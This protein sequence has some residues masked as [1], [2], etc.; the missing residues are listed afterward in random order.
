[1]AP[2]AWLLPVVAIRW[3]R[4]GRPAGRI[5]LG[6][7]GAAAALYFGW[8]GVASVMMPPA[9]YT[10][11]AATAAVV[12]VSPYLVDRFVAK[13]YDTFAQTLVFPTSLVT[14]EYLLNLVS[15]LG[16][17]NA[18]AY[19]QAPVLPLIQ[20]AA[21]TGIW[22]VSFVVAWFGAVVNWVFEKGFDWLKV[23]AGILFFAGALGLILLTGAA[24]V[25]LF[26]G[27]NKVVRVAGIC[28]RP[29]LLTAHPEITTNLLAGERLPA[30]ER[31][32][33]RDAASVIIDDLFARTVRE[34]R[35]GARIIVW[36][37]A[38]AMT[39]A[40]DERALIS[41]GQ[42]TARAERIYLAMGIGVLHDRDVKPFENKIV[43][44][45][46]AGRVIWNYRKSKP[47]PGPEAAISLAGDGRLPKIK[48]PFG[49]L[50]GSVCY[51][52]DFPAM[53]RAAG[54]AE[55]EA[56]LMLCP[57]HDWRELGELHNNIAVF[58][59]VEN[60]FS[61]IRPDND[62]VSLAADY[63]GRTAGITNYFVN[64]DGALVAYLPKLGTT[65][66]YEKGGDWF[67]WLNVVGL[68]ILVVKYSL[69]KRS[70][71]IR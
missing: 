15:P 58:R 41:R 24:R 57:A 34:A 71:Q 36:G 43:L 47:V 4:H 50:I 65:T 70:A 66:I 67:A 1:M 12:Y 18:V 20:L 7:A 35:A 60:G 53:I 28:A 19:T 14:L 16:T 52:M 59:A 32:A 68:I 31:L 13:K 61:L 42:E 33:L 9:L 30:A 8:R 25:F 44:I 48:T 3:F 11:F 38:S 2:G 23:R 54:R 39:L 55:P 46:P 17:W 10:A 40:E 49:V 5:P 26:P 27:G 64:E 29:F 37:E 6:I 69:I 63:H 62:G 51:D 45:D 22:G 21:L 56:D